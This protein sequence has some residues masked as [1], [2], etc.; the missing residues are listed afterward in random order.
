M[1][2]RIAGMWAIVNRQQ[3]FNRTHIHDGCDWSFAYYVK[4]TEDSGNIVFCDPRV[5]RV[6]NV[7][8]DIKWVTFDEMSSFEFPPAD[9]PIIKDL[10]GYYLSGG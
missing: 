7:H 6:M 5:R 1:S 9:I 10:C 8:D 3:H 4:V 2:F